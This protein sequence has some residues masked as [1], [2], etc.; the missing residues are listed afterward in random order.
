MRSM[1][2]HMEDRHRKRAEYWMAKGRPDYAKGSIR[3]AHKWAQR[4]REFDFQ[5]YGAYPKTQLD[6]LLGDYLREMERKLSD[7]LKEAMYGDGR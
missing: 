3:K 6:T 5:I 2:L 1:Y 7:S 4:R